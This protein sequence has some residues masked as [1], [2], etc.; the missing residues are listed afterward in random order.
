VLPSIRGDDSAVAPWRAILLAQQ[1]VVA[2]SPGPAALAL[3]AAADSQPETCRPAT[4]Y[5][6]GLADTQSTDEQVV[7]DG[8]LSLLTL[9]AVYRSQQPELAA[10]GLYHAAAALDKLKDDR[11][12]AAVRYELTSQFGATHF[13]AK[14]RSFNGEPK[15]MPVDAAPAA[16]R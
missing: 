3:R 14:A 13:G 7:R 11:G 9:P 4:L 16:S 6:L 1:E 10:A 12:A 2:G 8:I 15:A 5:W